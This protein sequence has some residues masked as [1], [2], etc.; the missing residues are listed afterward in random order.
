MGV[1]A[2]A[3]VTSKEGVRAKAWKQPGRLVGT[4]STWVKEGGV[5]GVARGVEISLISFNSYISISPPLFPFPKPVGE[6]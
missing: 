3:E 5:D 6:K 2:M 1:Q 4:M